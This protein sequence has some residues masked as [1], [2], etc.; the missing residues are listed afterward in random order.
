MVQPVR[1]RGDR[2]TD[3]SQRRVSVPWSMPR[4]M[5]ERVAEIAAER[6]V[7]NSEIAEEF[8]QRG[9]VECDVRKRLNGEV[10]A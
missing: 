1:R 4:W 8:V 3:E 5:V 10:A 2:I 7:R 6:G 9:L